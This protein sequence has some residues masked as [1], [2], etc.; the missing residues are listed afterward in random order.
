MSEPLGKTSRSG[1]TRWWVRLAV[2][3]VFCAGLLLLVPGSP[4]FL[5][6]V[7][8]A[9]RLYNGRSLA[10]WQHLLGSA[11]PEERFAAILGVANLAHTPAERVATVDALATI[12]GDDP[13]EIMRIQAA[14]GLCRLLPESGQAASVMGRALSDPCLGVRLNV[15][16]AL[17]GLGPLAKGELPALEKAIRDPRNRTNL[18]IF[19]FT[20][21]D[22]AIVAAGRTCAP[23]A[24]PILLGCQTDG[25]TEL[26][27]ICLARA[28]GDVECPSAQSGNRSRVLL[29]IAADPSEEV[30]LAGREALEK[31]GFAGQLPVKAAPVIV[32]LSLP[33]DQ[34][35]FL[36]EAE[37]HGN[38]L[39]KSAFGP[40]GKAMRDGD[41][42]GLAKMFASDFRGAEAA[43]TEKEELDGGYA[44]VRRVVGGDPS[45]PLDQL[46]GRGMNA[47]EF[48]ARLRGLLQPFG[49]SPA[50]LNAKLALMNLGPVQRDRLNGPWEGTGQLRLWGKRADGGPVEVVAVLRYRVA[51][52]DEEEKLARGGWLQAALITLNQSGEAPR[53]FFKESAVARGIEVSSLHDNW[54][55]KETSTTTG[56]VFLCD[57]N[58]DGYMDMLVTDENGNT[59]YLGTSSGQFE[60]GN[61]R[62]GLPTAPARRKC[63]AWID[64]D[65]DGWEDLVLSQAVYRN[66]AGKRL[67][68]CSAISTLFIPDDAL[69]LSIADYDRDGLIDIFIS[70]S[71]PPG[72]A[73]WLDNHA[74]ERKGNI[75]LRNKGAWQ[76][77]DVTR[78]AGARGGA[79]STF[80]AA[81]LDA[82]NDGWPDLHVPNEFGDGVLLVN[83]KDGTFKE[84]PLSDKPSDF[85]T[86]GLAAG[87]L[88]NDGNIDLYCGNMYSKAGTRVIAN[89]A[90]GAY[91]PE[92]MAKLRR[93][94]AGSQLHLNRGG[95]KFDSVGSA[96]RVAAVGWAYGPSLADLDNDGFLDIYGTAGYISKDPDE[97]DG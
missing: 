37:H 46:I 38:R 27:R 65:G 79:R 14:L 55:A 87:D 25:E 83:Q 91:S 61:A 50:E 11:D 47:A 93:F 33:E 41:W 34:R 48:V 13:D 3:L 52:P 86:M 72:T 64:I 44:T 59:L 31:T 68:E 32:E 53:P 77:E 21:R 9:P 71:A 17:T 76:F 92:V 60:K 96:M 62:L 94:V 12:L 22:S 70:R 15:A 29:E 18:G 23:E 95:L 97:P 81:W 58:H 20:I 84:R 4:F 89:M 57:M 69:N 66:E 75:L 19:F 90:D 2:L 73:S 85:G 80:S 7:V 51:Q 30:A 39:S 26:S 28:L 6:H 45:A 35:Q 42:A 82:N 1:L 43:A 78:H 54:R 24:L 10:Q 67:V 8:L 5:P 16:T 36:W 63:A 40:F 74:N 88:D 49:A 56:G